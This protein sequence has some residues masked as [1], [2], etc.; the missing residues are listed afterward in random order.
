MSMDVA[1]QHFANGK[2]LMEQ[3]LVMEAMEAYSTGLDLHWDC[4]DAQLELGCAYL[5]IEDLDS[6][7]RR[8]R[9]AVKLDPSSN[10]TRDLLE[11]AV[12]LREAR[13]RAAQSRKLLFGC[14]VLK[15]L[16]SGCEGA[17]YKV[18][19]PAS[20]KYILKNLY[21][22]TIY[23]INRSSAASGHD[24]SIG[25]GL[26]QI[27]RLPETSGAL[28]KIELIERDGQIQA[29][30]YSYERLREIPPHDLNDPAVASALLGA[31]FRTQAVLLRNWRLIL[32]DS[33]VK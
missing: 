10:E 6:A 22:S 19:D 20:G 27:V 7:I 12:K 31:F 11:K 23:Y 32:T 26:R 15:F 16:G 4:S 33:T 30:R 5:Q 3:G 18:R 24:P 21:P 9:I 2:M 13:N 17:V 14:K 28:Y 1:R 25:A 29:L 8:F